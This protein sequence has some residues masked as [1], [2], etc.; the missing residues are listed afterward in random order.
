MQPRG[1]SPRGTGSRTRGTQGTSQVHAGRAWAAVGFAT[2][3][4]KWAQESRDGHPD[5]W[6]A[7]RKWWPLDAAGTSWALR[8]GRSA[9]GRH[10]PLAQV[11]R[12]AASG[13]PIPPGTS[14]STQGQ[15][16]SHAARNPTSLPVRGA[17]TAEQPPVARPEPFPPPP[18]P[19]LTCC[20]PPS[21]PPAQ[22]AGR[23]C[24]RAP[25][26]CRQLPAR[27]PE[28]SWCCRRG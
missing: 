3:S 13:V 1:T 17:T 26:P 18:G 10:W 22:P 2:K 4:R 21:Q 8:A 11:L 25:A 12:R 23:P 7:S 19:S 5:V 14:H 28:R 27:A 20:S 6:Q 9:R 24:P 15:A 16:R